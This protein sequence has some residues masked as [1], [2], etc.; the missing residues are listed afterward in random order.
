[1]GRATDRALRLLLDYGFSVL[2]LHS[3]MLEV[4]SYN[5]RAIASTQVGFREI[6]RWR[7][8]GCRRARYDRLFM[9]ITARSSPGGLRA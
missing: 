6:G 4:Y 8:P 5:S 3:V 1:V 2:N 9:D 7:E